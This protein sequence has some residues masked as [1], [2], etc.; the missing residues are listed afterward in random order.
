MNF[1]SKISD[2]KIVIFYKIFAMPCYTPWSKVIWSMLL[3]FN[4]QESNCE[5]D[6]WPFFWPWLSIQNSKYCK[7]W[8]HFWY[9]HFKT[10]TIMYWGLNLLFTFLSQRFKT[11]WN[12]KFQIDFHFKML[13]AHFHPNLCKCAWILWCSS[14]GCQYLLGPKRLY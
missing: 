8:I 9:L 1:A 14:L 13:G 12:S 4:G 10:F 2:Y 5:F 11:L 3:G 7:V 6:S